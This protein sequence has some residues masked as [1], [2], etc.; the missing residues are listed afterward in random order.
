MNWNLVDGEK[1]PDKG[2]HMGKDMEML[3]HHGKLGT[4]YNHEEAPKN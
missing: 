1:K 3:N 4:Y 2:N